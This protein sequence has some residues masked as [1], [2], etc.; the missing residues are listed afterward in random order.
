M[1]LLPERLPDSPMPLICKWL[2]DAVADGNLPNPDAMTLVTVDAA[3]EPAARIV[4]CKEIVADAGYLVFYTNYDSA[5]GADI[6]ATKRVAAVFHWDHMNRQVRIEGLA[7]RS[8]ADESDAYFA[9]RD[10]ESQIGAWASNQSKPLDS[11]QQLLNK[12]AAT[13]RKLSALAVDTGIMPIPR[14]AF[15]GGY[16]IWISAAE[17]WV[18]G[19]ARLHDRGRWERQLE[20]DN[21]HEPQA[22]AWTAFRL[23]P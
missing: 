11:R 5:K 14:P 16:R 22:G 4:L 15:W 12:H 2:Q 18:R 8:P 7:V 23:Q 6:G 1:E 13:A 10:K 20:L 9:S 19:Q 21:G 17:L 3:G